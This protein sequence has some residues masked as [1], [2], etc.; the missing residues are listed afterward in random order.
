MVN[1]VRPEN[2]ELLHQSPAL[3][4]VRGLKSWGVTFGLGL[5]L[6]VD[7]YDYVNGDIDRHEYAASLTVDSGI[8]IGTA[9]VA[10][11]VAGTV[12]GTVAGAAGGSIVIPV[13]GS[14]PGAV[15]GGVVGGLVGLVTGLVV[16]LVAET[17]GV[18]DALVESVS[19]L[20]RSWTSRPEADKN[21]N[22]SNK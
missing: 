19:D 22:R 13:V 9:L 18:R 7:T 12:S 10:G 14:V 5:H 1:W 11:A 3:R 15:V 2:A 17:S 6:A 20:Y 4:A 16:G 8:T 21:K